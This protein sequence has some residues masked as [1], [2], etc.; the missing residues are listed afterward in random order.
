MVYIDKHWLDKLGLDKYGLD[1]H[2]LD[3]HGLGKHGL[4]KHGLDKH[5]LDIL[6]LTNLPAV[7]DL[8]L[9]LVYIAVWFLN[10]GQNTFN[11]V[12]LY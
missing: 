2:G 11:C 1:K 7:L 9:N 12:L 3:K 4:D 8:T 6:F 10:L 5:G